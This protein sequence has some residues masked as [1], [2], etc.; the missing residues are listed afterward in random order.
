M[1]LLTITGA[2][3]DTAATPEV[4]FFDDN[5]FELNIPVLKATS[6]SIT[7]AVPPY[8][9]MSTGMFGPGT[10]NLRVLQDSTGSIAASNA[11]TGFQIGAMPTLTLPLGG[12]TAN[13]AGFLELTLADTENRLLDLDTS[14]G[15]LINTADLR[16]QLENRKLQYG[17]LKTKIRN[18]IT[19]PGQAEIIGGINGLPITLDQTSLRISDQL[20]VATVNGILT[21]LQIT[22]LQGDSSPHSTN[23]FP[24]TQ[25]TGCSQPDDQVLCH[26]E[27][28]L[29][30]YTT[31]DGSEQQTSQEFL[32]AVVPAARDR[33]SKIMNWFGAT[34]ATIGAIAGLS[35]VAIPIGAVAAVTGVT[36]TGNIALYGMDASVLSSNSSDKD[37]AKRL[38]DDF[39]GSLE[40]TRD[41]V[42]SPTIGALS[43]KSGIIYDLYT[44]WKP[45]FEDKIPVFLSQVKTYI[46]APTCTFFTYSD[47]S[48]CQPT[49][50]QTRTEISRSPSGC[51]GA[52]LLIQ[53]CTYLPQTYQLTANAAGS[54]PGTVASNIG[55]ISFT[56]PGTASGSAT[57][58]NSVSVTLTATPGSGSLFA[59]WSGACTG[60]QST[61]TITMNAAKS[62]T[63]TFTATSLTCRVDL[64]GDANICTEISLDGAII[65]NTSSSNLDIYKTL[66]YGGHTLSFTCNCGY[67]FAH[68]YV[69]PYYTNGCT[70][71]PSSINLTPSDIP[72]GVIINRFF[73]I[74]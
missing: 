6:S 21:Q 67:C 28:T 66:T 40:F 13:I 9:S 23:L 62:V 7:V 39:N 71:T 11:I 74:N 36:V 33:L 69:E 51:N 55:G 52:P 54:G 2:G 35:E 37:A 22:A 63:A 19:N 18:A 57:L 47:W 34:A 15:G 59:G 29:T 53:S 20:M 25:A 14:S 30:G 8:I 3:F 12:V 31:V 26:M 46:D 60:T 5:G 64:G 38:L 4:S 50:T 44:G 16:A 48:P 61:C 72:D 24:L 32:Q 49:G 45:I 43:Q 58:N 73:T 27:K 56:Y 1:T 42:L 68:L 70:I 65:K 41:S 10:V 17:Q